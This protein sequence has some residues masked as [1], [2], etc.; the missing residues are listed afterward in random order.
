LAEALKKLGKKAQ[1]LKV[2]GSYPVR[3]GKW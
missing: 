3:K 1:Y 2:L